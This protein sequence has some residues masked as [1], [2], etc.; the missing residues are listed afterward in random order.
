MINL[1]INAIDT[2]MFRDGRP[3][4]QADAGASEAVS[5][6]P[7]YPPTIVGAI[8]AALWKHKGGAWPLDG[9]LGNGTNWQSGNKI[10]KPLRF[11]APQLLCDGVPVFPVPL[12]IV[13][14]KNGNRKELTVL[15]PGDEHDC[16][17]GNVRLPEPMDTDLAG[18]KT[19][20]DRWVTAAGMQKILNGELPDRERVKWKAITPIE[21]CHFVNRQRLW[22]AEPRVGIGIERKSRTTTDGQL[23]MATHT[24]MHAGVSLHVQLDGYKGMHFKR[25]LQP[26]AGEHRMA[27]ITIDTDKAVKPPGMSKNLEGGRYCIIL[28]SPLVIDKMLRAGDGFD[29]LPGVVVSACIGKPVGIGGWNS[30]TKPYGSIPLRQCIPAGSVFF[31]KDGEGLNTA[32]THHIG[33]A[34]EWGFGQVLIGKWQER[35]IA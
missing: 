1:Q 13:E 8:R 12:H 5:I 14:G 15:A 22:Q 7:P 20:E 3:F 33:M 30:T 11:G 25:A 18:I 26:L 6:F 24:R 4:N 23:Y 28:L 16:D 17:L 10:L 21:D 34:S 9:S 19:I 35:H 29:G 2:L 27:E 31:M 32:K